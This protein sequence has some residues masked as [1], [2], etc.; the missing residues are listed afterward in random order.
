[1]QSFTCQSRQ[2]ASLP[3]PTRYVAT[4]MEEGEARS[5]GAPEVNAVMFISVALP[6]DGSSAKPPC[7]AGI[8]GVYVRQRAVAEE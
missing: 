4:V 2:H 5:A 7:S 1:V 3:P 8:S 6:C